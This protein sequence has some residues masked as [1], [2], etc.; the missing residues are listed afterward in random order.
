MKTFEIITNCRTRGW[1][2][3]EVKAKTEK[4]AR[5]LYLK[6]EGEFTGEEFEVLDDEIDEIKKVNE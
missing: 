3:W 5:E 2:T 6:G 1:Q 4:E